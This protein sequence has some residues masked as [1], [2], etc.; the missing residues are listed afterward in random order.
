M[1]RLGK[2]LL[3]IAITLIL[4]VPFAVPLGNIA[5]GGG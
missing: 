3:A 5:I 2:R 4:A 1:H